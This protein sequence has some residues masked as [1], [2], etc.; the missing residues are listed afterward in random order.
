MLLH[1][2]KTGIRRLKKRKSPS[3]G[4]AS[5]LP[6]ELPPTV[7][8]A[9]PFHETEDESQPPGT[10]HSALEGQGS[11]LDGP[12]QPTIEHQTANFFP[13]AHDFTVHNPVLVTQFVNP[14]ET[15]TRTTW[16]NYTVNPS[17]SSDPIACKKGN[18]CCYSRFFR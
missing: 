11:T 7:A 18:P 3:T 14:G 8:S 6:P 12:P 13:H 5:P 16:F 1:K 17:R 15:G 2:F 10:S 9:G 4:E